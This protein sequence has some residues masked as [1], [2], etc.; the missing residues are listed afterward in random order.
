METI[1]PEALLDESSDAL[2]VQT[3]SVAH[4]SCSGGNEGLS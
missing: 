1:S 3:S 4:G 2:F